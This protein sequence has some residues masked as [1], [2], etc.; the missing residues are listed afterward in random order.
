[1]LAHLDRSGASDEDTKAA[2]VIRLMRKRHDDLANEATDKR[3]KVLELEAKLA[4]TPA[5]SDAARIANLEAVA[6]GAVA[7]RDRVFAQHSADAATIATL[8]AA[9]ESIAEHTDP[10]SEEENYRA[11]D[12]EGCLDT[13]HAIATAALANTA[14]DLRDRG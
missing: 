5:L 1:V 2:T 14:I 12:R 3:V 11:D 13:A 10:D 6:A 9:L 8:R 4:A 7:D